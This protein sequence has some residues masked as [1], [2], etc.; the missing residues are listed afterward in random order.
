MVVYLSNGMYFKVKRKRQIIN[1]I[2]YLCALVNFYV[3]LSLCKTKFIRIQF[4][5]KRECD[6]ITYF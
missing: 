4:T 6:Y 2:Y 3:K 5:N 1:R